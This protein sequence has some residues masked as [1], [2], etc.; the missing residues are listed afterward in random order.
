MSTTITAAHLL[1]AANVHRNNCVAHLLTAANVHRNNC[2][3]HLLTA[4]NVHRNNCVVHLLTA[5]NVHCNNCAAHLFT[6]ANVHCNNCAAHLL[7]AANVHCNNCA[8][9]LLTAANV[10]C[11]NCAAHL[12]TAANVQHSRAPNNSVIINN[13]KKWQKSV[14]LN[15]TSSC[16]AKMQSANKTQIQK[17]T[18]C[19]KRTVHCYVNSTERFIIIPNS[20]GEN[21]KPKPKKTG[22]FAN[23]IQTQKKQYMKEAQ[24]IL[25][26]IQQTFLWRYLIS[27]EKPK[28]PKIPPQNWTLVQTLP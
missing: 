24:N 16:P 15:I 7:T 1:T 27:V 28:T 4:A 23:K 13:F 11:N 20:S 9:H 21:P 5:A 2:A 19:L 12:L 10:H 18:A 25:L 22:H 8:A 17:S 6:A 26:S 14:H 3:A